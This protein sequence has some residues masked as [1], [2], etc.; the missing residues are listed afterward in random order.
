M[1]RREGGRW[2]FHCSALLLLL[3]SLPTLPLTLWG[4]QWAP[5]SSCFLEEATSTPLSRRVRVEGHVA[6]PCPAMHLQED[7]VVCVRVSHR[8]PRPL[9]AQ[10]TGCPRQQ[11]GSLRAP[12]RLAGLEYHRGGQRWGRAEPGM[13]LRSCPSLLIAVRE[14]QPQAPTFDLFHFVLK[15][16]GAPPLGWASTVPTTVV[17]RRV[18]FEQHHVRP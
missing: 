16:H 9:L 10:L 12:V 6:S 14:L 18:V 2:G 4:E 8:V 15:R 5:H 7:G 3:N 17:I 13:F 11:L 1:S